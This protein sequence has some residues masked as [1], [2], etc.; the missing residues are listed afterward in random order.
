M[1]SETSNSSLKATTTIDP[2]IAAD[3]LSILL[4]PMTKEEL[5]IE[6]DAWLLL[7]RDVAKQISIA[8][9]RVKK[10]NT[11]ISNEKEINKAKDKINEEISDI[12]K[13]DN[14]E[15]KKKLK[16][17]LKKE[18]KNDLKDEIKDF[19]K[20]IKDEI[21]QDLKNEI[22]Q[23]LKEAEKQDE[24]DKTPVAK[25]DL[26]EEIKEDVL[27]DLD[28]L[29]AERRHRVER[30]NLVLSAINEKV[31]LNETG[32]ELDEVMPYR[33]YVNAVS[34]L[35]LDVTDTK[36]TWISIKGYLLSEDGGIK[37]IISS[38][39]FISIILIFW[40]L[41]KILSNAVRKALGFS[42]RQSHILKD[43]FINSVSRLTKIIGILVA[44][45]AVGISVAPIMAIIGAAGFVVAF[46]LQ[47]TLSNFAS[48]IMIM[49]YRP[50][51]EHDLIEVAGIMGKVK[52]M[53]LVS[54]TIL[55]ADN[56]LMII[57]NNTIWGDV[58]VNAHYSKERR[59]DM[60]FGIGYGDDIEQAIQVMT[61][62]LADHPLVLD[63]PKSVIQVCE[64]A[65]SSVNFICRPW[66]KTENYWTVYW[67]ITRNVK[68]QFD[69]AGISIPFPQTDV[70]IHQQIEK[71]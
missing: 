50:F 20:D 65:D 45:S 39:T 68:E 61:R 35:K 53:T 58:I 52:S 57:P 34:G 18:I 30:I 46:A 60:I 70:H 62:V 28:K 42:T 6:A 48:G 49:L 47:S 63:E 71:Q 41:S 29:R 16:D 25:I 13:I 19:K 26:I 1:A 38:S 2:S 64:L 9:L 37:W 12:A 3:E 31:G 44:L 69:A 66:T 5:F 56:K 11:K 54:T 17:D 15:K 24:I 32:G 22:K 10:T 27:A 43:F 14:A 67:D 21:K 8:Q 59:V 55:T 51:D 40:L 33:R 7:L 4:V 36:S 23:D